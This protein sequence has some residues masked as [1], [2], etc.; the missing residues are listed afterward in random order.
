[1]ELVVK[2]GVIQ[3]R[4]GWRHLARNLIRSKESFFPAECLIYFC[5]LCVILQV[6]LVYLAS[7]S[8]F[9]L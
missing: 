1:M 4:S 7:V 3:S 6:T 2:L 9:S 5:D 8:L